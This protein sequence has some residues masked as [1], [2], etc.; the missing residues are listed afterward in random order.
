MG[1][2]RNLKKKL[3]NLADKVLAE[4]SYHY[5]IQKA[6]QTTKRPDNSS[7]TMSLRKDLT[8]EPPDTTIATSFQDTS[9]KTTMNNMMTTDT[10]VAYLRNWSINKVETAK[11]I[12]DKN[13]IYK[14]F[15]EWIEIEEGDE[16]LEIMSIDADD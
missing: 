2:V 14:E 13:A 15:E 4:L 11:S 7:V 5:M 10:M 3:N 8:M 1:L 16:D 9:E 12:G 6:R